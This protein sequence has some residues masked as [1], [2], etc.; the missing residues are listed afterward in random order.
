MT[1]DV[2][3]EESSTPVKLRVTVCPAKAAS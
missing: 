2:F 3:S 1:K